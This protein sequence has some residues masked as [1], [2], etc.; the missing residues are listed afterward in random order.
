[1]VTSLYLNFGLP[2]GRLHSV[3]STW[4]I[5]GRGSLDIRCTCASHRIRLCLRNMPTSLPFMIVNLRCR[6]HTT[7]KLP[8]RRSADPRTR[9]RSPAAA[10]NGR[11]RDRG[12]RERGWTDSGHLFGPSDH[13]P[14]ATTPLLSRCKS[15]RYIVKRR[16][17]TGNSSFS[18]SQ[19]FTL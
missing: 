9:S 8:V 19:N 15:E 12:G 2:T 6:R 7:A 11:S 1:M 3:N 13:R 10:W 18:D 16:T 17:K 4:R 5:R 14:H